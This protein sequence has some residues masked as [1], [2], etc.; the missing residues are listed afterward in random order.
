MKPAFDCLTHVGEEVPPIGDLQRLGC[1]EADASGIFSRAVS[2]DD[3]DVRPPFEPAGQRRRGAVRKKV[4]H[5]MAVQ[6]HHD[7]TVAAAFPHRP[8]VDADVDR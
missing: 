5:A 8:I 2:G 7:R 1:A 4:D 6:V 3:P